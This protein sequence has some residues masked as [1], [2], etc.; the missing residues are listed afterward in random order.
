MGL[1]TFKSDSKNQDDSDTDK[2]NPD[3]E[4]DE[5]GLESFKSHTDRGGNTNK[6]DSE[7]DS[8]K[9]LG[10]E[11]RKWNSMSVKERVAEVRDS[12]I[13]DFRPEVQLDERWSHGEV[14]ELDCVCNNIFH[15]MHTGICMN[16]GRTYSKKGRTV[17]KLSDPDDTV[18]HDNESN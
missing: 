9:V 6:T 17:I 8:D 15:F 13:P 16:C 10:V 4:S 5:G 14:V 12:K 2:D 7:N 1:D 11:P 18:I 3:N